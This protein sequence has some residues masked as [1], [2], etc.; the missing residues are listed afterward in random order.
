MSSV[1]YRKKHRKTNGICLFMIELSP[2]KRAQLG[3]IAK[4]NNRSGA[5][6]VRSWIDLDWLKLHPEKQQISLN[7]E[8]E[9]R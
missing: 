8:L 2:E 1:E 4:L 9:R 5:A 3:E 6:Q 7:E